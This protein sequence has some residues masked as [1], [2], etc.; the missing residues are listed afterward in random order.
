[1]INVTKPNLPPLEEFVP[2]LESIWQS[3]VLSNNGPYHTLLEQSLVEY[4][5]VD[6]VS[7]VSNATLGLML[8]QYVLEIRNAEIITT[9]YSFVATT[10][11]ILWMN[12]T[13]VFVDIEPDSA[14]L[15]PELIEAAVTE[16]TRAI[17]PL[18]C[19]GNMVNVQAL[20]DIAERHELHIIY[21]ACHSFGVEDLG[22][23]A[24]RHGDM[25]VVSF[26]ATK[27]FNTFEGGLIVSESAELKEKVDRAK[28]FGFVDEETITLP[29]I[30]AKLNEPAAA[31]GLLQLKYLDEYFSS[32]AALDAAYRQRMTAVPGIEPVATVRQVKRNY[33]YFPVV[34]GDSFRLTRDE[35]VAALKKEGINCRKYFYPLIPNFQC[36]ER[37]FGQKGH[38][39]VAERLASQILCLPIYPEMTLAQCHAICDA[40]QSG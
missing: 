1:M 16:R 17:M 5:G 6:H 10:N 15:D 20:E 40:I 3:G 11:S 38:W 33:A 8:A 29:G 4:L 13:P 12:N 18:H 14:C 21:D 24:L 27:V 34:I 2:M 39:P 37:E 22:G 31:F 7:L 25:S 30:N 26:H 28:N 19:Y 36:F 23:S 35:L 32:R 9:P